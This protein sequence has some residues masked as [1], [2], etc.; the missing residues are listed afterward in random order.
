[1]KQKLSDIEF[2]FMFSSDRYEGNAV[3]LCKSTGRLYYVSE[4][5]DSDEDLPDDLDDHER[6]LV[7]PDKSDLDLDS[8][9]VHRFMRKHAASFADEVREIFSSK[10]A[11]RRFKNFLMDHDLLDQWHAYESEETTAAIRTWCQDNG[12]E[13]DE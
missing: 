10:G 13:L 3:Y 12:I 9:L 8:Q 11:Y 5:G 2:A 7:L 6:Y 4:Y 1:M